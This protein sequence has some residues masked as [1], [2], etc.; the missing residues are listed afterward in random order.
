MSEKPQDVNGRC[1]RC[2]AEFAGRV[3]D[4]ALESWGW[5]KI[6]GEWICNF[7]SGAGYAGINRAGAAPT[8]GLEGA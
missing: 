2:Q 7:C 4:K 8:E 3:T 1:A 5:R 6:N